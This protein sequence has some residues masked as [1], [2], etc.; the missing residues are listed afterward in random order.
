MSNHG[1]NVQRPL[2]AALLI[3]ISGNL[4]VGS[5]P[6]PN[7]VNAFHRLRKSHVP[8][9][10]CK[11]SSKESTAALVKRLEVVAGMDSHGASPSRRLVWTSIGAVAQT[12][13]HELGS[14]EVRNSLLAMH[15]PRWLTTFHSP[16][17]LLTDSARDEV[18]SGLGF[19]GPSKRQT[20]QEPNQTPTLYDS[21]VIGLAP[22]SF[23]YPT[24]NTAFRILKGEPIDKRSSCMANDLNP[25]PSIRSSPPIIATHKAK[26]IQT[27]SGLS[28]GAGPFV[29]ALE[30]AS[31]VCAYIVGKPT[32]EFFLMV[33][34]DFT[35]EE[36]LIP[37]NIEHSGDS[38][39][40]VELESMP[41]LCLPPTFNGRIAVIGDDVEADLGGGAVELG[42]S[43]S[44][45]NLFIPAVKTAKYRTDDEVRPSVV[46][47]DEVFDTFAEFV[48]RLL[49]DRIS[50]L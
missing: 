7:A 14:E 31:A 28:L 42:L 44:S 33:I 6:T 48:D 19:H 13:H 45:S 9:I 40:V 49:S 41:R 23:N 38:P 46:P 50:K 20:S 34:D 43:F 29:V 21:V 18:T 47:P 39:R 32:K 27:E 35:A 3:D 4:H 1:A 30:N 5:T 2:I 36:L 37:A 12:I 22:S 24:L 8:F 16:L 25:A 15:Y 26:Y 11:N 10:L 17:L